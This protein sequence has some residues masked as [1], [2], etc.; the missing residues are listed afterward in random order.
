MF[1]VNIRLCFNK[2]KISNSVQYI[3]INQFLFGNQFLCKIPF[4][5][6]QIQ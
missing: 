5:K 2:S 4:S 1:S 3:V 6:K